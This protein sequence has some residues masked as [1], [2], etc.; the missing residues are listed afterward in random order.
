MRLRISLQRIRRVSVEP[1]CSGRGR[2]D[3]ACHG[4]SQLLDAG[5]FDGEHLDSRD[6]H[7][8]LWVERQLNFEQHNGRYERLDRFVLGFWERDH[9]DWV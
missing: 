3:G 2:I 6:E 5:G 9:R 4:S 7:R 1:V 8:E